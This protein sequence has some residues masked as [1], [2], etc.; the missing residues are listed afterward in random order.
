MPIKKRG[1]VWVETVTYTL[2]AFVLIGLVLAYAKPKID[3]LQDKAILEQSTNMINQINSVIQQIT[4]QGVGNKRKIDFNIKKGDLKFNA[5]DNSIIFTM[6]TKL[7]YSQPGQTITDSGLTLLTTKS[8]DQY[9][10]NLTKKYYDVNFTIS[11]AK[12]SRD[13]TK[14]VTPYTMYLTN[15]G[16]NPTNIDLVIE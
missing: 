2:I 13:L 5:S 4:E 1:Q 16:G 6:Q 14:S 3:S 15:K 7:M 11:G 10:V 9:I 12:I 8:G